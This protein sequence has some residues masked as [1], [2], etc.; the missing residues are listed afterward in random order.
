MANSPTQ[1]TAAPP[2]LFNLPADLS[3]D[4]V[5]ILPVLSALLSRLKDPSTT[6][7]STSGS[8]PAASPSQLAVGN[9]S[10]TI[11][12]IPAA[13]DELKHKLHRARA[14][15]K[16]LP[17]MERSIEDQ[18]EEIGEWV[19]RIK[20]QREVLEK[21]REVGLK[22]K[23]EREQRLRAAKGEPMET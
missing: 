16:E 12:D 8:P 13:T 20:R 3:P 2:S 15:I 9:G 17:D 6:G 18:E 4:S 1:T 7:A 22:A 19:D 5:D 10:L 23:M 21:L 14:Q 11:K